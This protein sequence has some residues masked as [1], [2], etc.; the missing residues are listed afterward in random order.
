MSRRRNGSGLGRT[1]AM[2]AGMTASVFQAP[3]ASANSV[4]FWNQ[5]IQ[6]LELSAPA[7]NPPSTARDL[8][9]MNVAMY[10][11][12]SAALGSPT[13]IFYPTGPV[14]PGASAAAA[15]DGAAYAYLLQRFPTKAAQIDAAYQS[16]LAL[17]PNNAATAAGLTL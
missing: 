16:Q 5:T 14:A 17:L 6:A 2:F 12:V 13:K 11:A 7:P 9:I 15:A 10:D 8:S 4:L 1:A 3:S